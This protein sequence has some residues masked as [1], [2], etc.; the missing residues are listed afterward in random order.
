MEVLSKPWFLLLVFF[1][2]KHTMNSVVIVLM[3][4]MTHTTTAIPTVR[5]RSAPLVGNSVVGNS[6][7]G[8][9]VVGNFV[10]GNSVVGTMVTDD[11]MM[12]LIKGQLLSTQ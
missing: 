2:T 10:V 6:V 8:N 4:T 9:S 5:Y 3:I 11:A 1:L 7:V 12:E